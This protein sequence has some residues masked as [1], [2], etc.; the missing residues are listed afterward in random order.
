MKILIIQA[1]NVGYREL[2]RIADFIR[3]IENGNEAFNNLLEDTYNDDLII[4]YDLKMDSVTI[5]GDYPFPF[6]PEDLG[7]E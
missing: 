6:Y 3:K 7:I 2:S 5:K 1:N 4:G